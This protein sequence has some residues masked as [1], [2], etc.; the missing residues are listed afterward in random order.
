MSRIGITK[1]TLEKAIAEGREVDDKKLAMEMCLLF[2]CSIRTAAEY[3]KLARYQI[4][5]QHT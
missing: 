4:G 3:V 2:R 1:A 5:I